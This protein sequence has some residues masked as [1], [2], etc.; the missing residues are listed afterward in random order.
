MP[1]FSHRDLQVVAAIAHLLA[2]PARLT[3]EGTYISMTGATSQECERED[4]RSRLRPR[5]RSTAAC[6]TGSSSSKSDFPVD[7]PGHPSSNDAQDIVDNYRCVC[8][9]LRAF[10]GRVLNHE[11]KAMVEEIGAEARATALGNRAIERHQHDEQEDTMRSRLRAKD[12]DIRERAQFSP[13]K[14]QDD[15]MDRFLRR[16][17]E[18]HQYEKAR[19]ETYCGKLQRQA[20]QALQAAK[21]AQVNIMC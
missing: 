3:A 1:P 16:Q 7:S 14:E 6:P 17:E 15:V 20:R 4:R 5:P 21:S 11:E 2:P 19:L 9:Q 10:R 18:E 13:C 8:Q 12:G